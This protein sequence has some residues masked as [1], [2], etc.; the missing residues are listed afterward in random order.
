MGHAEDAKR[1][2][3]L[4]EQYR[5]PAAWLKSVARE[6]AL[7]GGERRHL[8][9][10]PLPLWCTGRARLRERVGRNI[11]WAIHR[12]FGLF[13]GYGY[14][15]LFAL[16][17]LAGAWLLGGLLLLAAYRTDGMIPN[18]PFTLRSDEW[19]ACAADPGGVT[20]AACYVGRVK[21]D[22]DGGEIGPVDYPGFAAGWYALDTFVPFVDLHQE[23]RWIPD[24]SERWSWGWVARGYLYVHIAVGWVVT[25]LFAASVTGLV[26]RDD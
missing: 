4:K 23:P 17:W 22:G 19:A 11:R 7:P 12:A 15:P 8:L 26:K 2:G 13:I 24:A 16:G 1:I 18:D 14:R 9:G 20:R 25:A 21:T 6:A 3:I 10:A 5:R